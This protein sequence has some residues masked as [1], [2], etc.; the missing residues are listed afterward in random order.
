MCS[1]MYIDNIA[2]NGWPLVSRHQ[3]K[4]YDS[5]VGFWDIGRSGKVTVKFRSA[6]TPGKI[7]YGH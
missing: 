4:F 6:E 7:D 5:D 3:L 1:G 2:F